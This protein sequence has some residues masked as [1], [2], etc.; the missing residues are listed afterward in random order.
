[1]K[2]DIHPTYYPEAR[3][4]CACGSTWTTGSTEPELRV[5]ICSDCHPFFTGEQRIVDTAG[6][7]DRFMKR[8]NRYSSHQQDA[9]TRKGKARAKQ[10][11]KFARQQ[12]AV[13]D[14]NDRVQ[15]ALHDENIVTLGDLSKRLTNNRDAMLDITGFTP[16]IVDDLDAKLQDA[17][18]TFFAEPA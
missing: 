11:Q 16:E 10:E 2:K 13:L 7:V 6:Q 8:L 15:Q 12:I 5:Y 9:T 4:A 3:V 17:R 1:M 18:T 14:L